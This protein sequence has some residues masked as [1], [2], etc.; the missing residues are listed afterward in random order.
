VATR[1]AARSLREVGIVLDPLLRR[2]ELSIDQIDNRDIR[3]PVESQI[4]F[5]GLAAKALHEPMLGFRLACEVDLREMGLLHYTA[6]AA[7]TLGEAL[8]RFERYCSIVTE[9]VTLKCVDSDSLKIELGYAGVARHS[10]QQQMEFIATGLIRSF[11]ALT[12]SKLK[13]TV[14]HF[15]HRSSREHAAELSKYFGCRIIFGAETD[16][17]CLDKSARQLAVI[18]ADPYLSHILLDYCEQALANRRSNASSLRT[19]IENAITP[20]LPHGDASFNEVA[21]KL[22]MGRRTLARRLKAEGLSFGEILKQLRADLI[23]RYLGESTLSISQVAWLV[24]FRSVAAFSHSCKRSNG[25]NP[26][27]LREK[28][29]K[30]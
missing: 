24:G 3:I 21:R 15:V 23:A 7:A 19:T 4:I 6:G 11:R 18:G 16:T 26:K 20:L 30:G 8:Q 1:L 28:L 13:P 9:G 2:A 22:G 25:M 14:V 12:G 10:D 29:L 5:L 27:A 17:I